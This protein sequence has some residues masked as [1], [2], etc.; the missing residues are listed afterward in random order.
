MIEPIEDKSEFL[1]KANKAYREGHPIV[2][3]DVYDY[4]EKEV[5]RS[6]PDDPVLIEIEDHDFGITKKLTIAMGSQDKAHNLDEMNR[7]YNRINT[8]DL[9]SA[10][11]KLDG[12]S[13]ELTYIYGNFVLAL[14]RGDGDVGVDYT[15]LIRNAKDLPKTIKTDSKVT[16]VRGEVVLLKEDF[17]ELNKLLIADGREPY[18][19]TRNG[20][21]GLVKTLKNR[22]YSKFLSVRAFDVEEMY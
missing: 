21:V 8:Q 14:S 17:K 3:D 2:S 4:L 11:G 1:R 5:R 13:I 15:S 10:S 9:I 20:A 16:V 7:F 19:N 22:K 6:N 12:F 18:Q